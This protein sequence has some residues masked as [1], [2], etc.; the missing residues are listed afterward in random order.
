M[1]DLEISYGETTHSTGQ[2]KKSFR[3]KLHDFKGKVEKFKMERREKENI[4]LDKQIMDRKENLDIL[5]KKQL[6]M[7]YDNQEK[8][9]KEKMKK[10][11]SFPMEHKSTSLFGN[12]NSSYKPKMRY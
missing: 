3:E 9:I 2:K 12:M 6:L 4:R 11:K 8:K 10:K 7:N 1:M 5:K